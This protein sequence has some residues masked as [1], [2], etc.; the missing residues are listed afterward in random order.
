MLSTAVKGIDGLKWLNTICEPLLFIV[1]VIGMIMALNKFG[2][3]NMWSSLQQESQCLWL[4]ESFL[5]L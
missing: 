1:F 5:L 3:G 4:T 2:T